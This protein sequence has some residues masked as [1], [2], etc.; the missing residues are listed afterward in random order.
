MDPLTIV[1]AAAAMGASF[2]VG[3]WVG[4]RAAT[5]DR[6]EM[7]YVETFARFD[8][9]VRQLAD[10]THAMQTD[11]RS[12]TLA[13]R[14]DF[15]KRGDWG[16][17]TLERLLEAAGLRSGTD[18]VTQHAVTG[19]DESRGRVDVVIHLPGHRA[20]AIDCKVNLTAWDA[21][22]QAQ[23]AG[24]EAAARTALTQHVQALKKEIMELSRRDYPG[25][26]QRQKHSAAPWTLMFVPMES[27]L[28][29]AL[30]A[31]R[32]D[33]LLTL[34]RKQRVWPIGPTA[35]L[36]MLGIV[37]HVWGEHLREQN[38]QEIASVGGKLFDKI[39]TFTESMDKTE[40]SIRQA[41]SQIETARKQLTTG[42][43]NAMREAEKL[44]RMGVEVKKDL[45]RSF[46]A[47]DVTETAGPSEVVGGPTSLQSPIPAEERARAASHQD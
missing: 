1:A 41:L 6:R 34:A 20:I 42:R 31:D 9:R 19:D 45:P 2:A 30:Q 16:E 10:Q 23:E 21:Y 27:A 28:S 40:N 22:A 15:K 43:G 24:D 32:H 47:E 7:S 17:M 14:G 3:W 33:E 44:K 29:E 4:S 39:R 37:N 36:P 5:K 18:Y 8:E 11:A 46:E 25:G 26:L 38:A 13:L 35:L 12:L